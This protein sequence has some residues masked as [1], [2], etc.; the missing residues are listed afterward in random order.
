MIDKALIEQ[1]FFASQKSYNEAA[2][3]QKEVAEKLVRILADHIRDCTMQER[4]SFD[5]VFE[6]GCGSGFLT[7]E[8]LE[9]F[10]IEDYIANDIARIDGL[11]QGARFLKGDAER[12]LYPEGCSLIVSSSCIQWFEDMEDFF[13]RVFSALEEN[14]L[15][16]LSTF[17]VQTLKE[18][19][20][21]DLPS[22]DYRNLEELVAMSKPY[23]TPIASQS[24]TVEQYFASP[25][26][27]LRSLKATGVNALSRERWTKARYLDFERG[28]KE[29]FCFERGCRLTYEPIYL[30]LKKNETI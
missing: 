23:F 16:L 13:G 9:S 4:Q 24:E 30:L 26:E 3:V 20:A 22:L 8:L 14:G 6:I 25:K 10:P 11:P 15:L 7:R 29:R 12:I 27:V 19:R 17:G 5:R 28:Y 1:R 21:L 18:F 2:G